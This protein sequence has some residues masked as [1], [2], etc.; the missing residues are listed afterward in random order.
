MSSTLLRTCQTPSIS[1]AY[2]VYGF[3][4]FVEEYILDILD[5]KGAQFLDVILRQLPKGLLLPKA[6]ISAANA[7]NHRDAEDTESWMAV[8]GSLDCAKAQEMFARCWPSGRKQRR[9]R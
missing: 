1:Q 7:V 6:L 3:R 9:G 4:V 2:A 8:S 5:Q